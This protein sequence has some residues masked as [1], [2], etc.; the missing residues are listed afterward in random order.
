MISDNYLED[1]D[2]CPKEAVEILTIAD[3]IVIDFLTKFTA[4][5]I[6]S[7]DTLLRFWY[8]IF[9]YRI[10]PHTFFHNSDKN[11]QI[12]KLRIEELEPNYKLINELS[13]NDR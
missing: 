8:L 4:K 9:V 3:H 6:H 2:Q 5:Q 1:S 7:E 12:D 10:M 11:S 13:I